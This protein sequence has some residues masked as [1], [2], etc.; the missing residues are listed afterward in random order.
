MR[1]VHLRHGLSMQDVV[2]DDYRLLD[3]LNE[4]LLEEA[5]RLHEQVSQD[6]PSTPDTPVSTVCQHFQMLLQDHVARLRVGYL[7]I[8]PIAPT[9]AGPWF[10]GVA[11]RGA[12]DMS[13]AALADTL[14]QNTTRIDSVR[15]QCIAERIEQALPSVRATTGETRDGI[16]ALLKGRLGE[17]AENSDYPF[18]TPLQSMATVVTRL[19]PMHGIDPG[20]LDDAKAMVQKFNRLISDWQDQKSWPIDPLL[21]TATHMLLASTPCDNFG[22]V[23]TL[24]ALLIDRTNATTSTTADRHRW[25]DHLSET[26]ES[27]LRAYDPLPVFDETLAAEEILRK[28]G[29]SPDELH[30]DVSATHYVGAPSRLGGT[31]T[32]TTPV[33]HFLRSVERRTTFYFDRDPTRLIDGYSR[34]KHALDAFNKRLQRRAEIPAKIDE[35][36]RLAG[37]DN[38][39]H[40]RASAL[41]F[42]VGMN[43][44]NSRAPSLDSPDWLSF[45]EA[46]YDMLNRITI[47][48]PMLYVVEQAQEGNW[49][50]VAEMVPFLVPS[51]EVADGIVRRNFTTF[52]D[53]VVGLGVDALMGSLT[54]IG[55]RLLTRRMEQAFVETMRMAPSQR[56]S[57]SMLN[58]LSEPLAEPG[59]DANA[60]AMSLTHFNLLSADS[61][62]SFS[63]SHASAIDPFDAFVDPAKLPVQV[64]RLPSIKRLP[65]DARPGARAEPSFELS[66]NDDIEIFA[67]QTPPIEPIVP[68]PPHAPLSA[69]ALEQQPTVIDLKRWVEGPRR[70]SLTDAM[71]V[72][73]DYVSARAPLTGR[74]LSDLIT[75]TTVPG[76]R[77]IARLE[78]LAE[79]SP[80]FRAIIDRASLPENGQPWKLEVADGFPPK[81]NPDAGRIWLCT[82]E[83]FGRR[84]YPT[85]SGTTTFPA[86][87]GW[88]HECLHALTD[89]K[90]P[91]D[92]AQHRGAIVYLTDRIG[93]EAGWDYEERVIY[94]SPSG[95]SVTSSENSH[96][97][98]VESP[99]TP[100]SDEV[101]ARMHDENRYLDR[102]LERQMNLR[103]S[104]HA[105]AQDVTSRATVADGL[106]LEQTLRF[107]RLWVTSQSNPLVSPDVSA[108][109]RLLGTNTDLLDVSHR[110]YLRSRLYRFLYHRWM[111]GDNV[112]QWKIVA[113]TEA[114]MPS[115]SRGATQAPWKINRALGEIEMHSGP[116]YYLSRSGPRYMTMTHRTVGALTELITGDL[117]IRPVGDPNVER[118]L[119][120]MLE[121]SLM[122]HAH[123]NVRISSAYARE[124]G[125]LLEYTTRA[126]RV[127]RIEDRELR[128]LTRLLRVG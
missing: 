127:A 18:G 106:R 52:S 97:G 41:K 56:S 116:V 16:E 24:S 59:S 98:Q 2:S 68:S 109:G 75:S 82:E 54:H 83:E 63:D 39:S 93:F 126:N 90:D 8:P 1:I 14:A 92:G 119:H 47:A 110:L 65:E 112:G 55:G 113:R 46:A 102:M 38:T 9:D 122:Q 123:D 36:I 5:A 107:E 101:V 20:N 57:M 96:S 67:T 117:R 13:V 73:Y 91:I 88:L 104:T 89:L 61:V 22:N 86:E 43:N 118:G 108:P 49:R 95:S 23:T 29:F 50:A 6:A 64:R 105:L 66:F 12:Q 35:L 3:G 60:E 72:F 125:T 45:F 11:V 30:R 115:S 78:S 25:L 27:R 40:I 51:W 37:V 58:V 71:R 7:L 48:P 81:V 19:G 34:M 28:L 17:L 70:V 76:K 79:K 128:G 120:V 10:D 94:R 121:N 4:T 26:F 15:A 103:P 69:F 74:V 114:E 124:P 32:S 44:R 62:S 21:V 80:T 33:D 31:A 99:V 85:R 84:R 53:G 77:V 42:I 87:R 100:V 111:P